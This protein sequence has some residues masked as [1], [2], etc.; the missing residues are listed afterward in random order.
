[1]IET[2]AFSSIL[3]VLFRPGGARQFFGRS[4]QFLM[5]RSHLAT[6][7]G[8]AAVSLR[9]RLGAEPTAEG[10]LRTIEA[11]LLRR[12]GSDK[13]ALHPAVN[14]ALDSLRRSPHVAQVQ[15]I[16]RV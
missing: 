8:K 7:G 10:M 14:F 1:M 2:A 16:T 11:E 5:S 12:L 3:G 13:V 4:D 6:C 15:E 9:D